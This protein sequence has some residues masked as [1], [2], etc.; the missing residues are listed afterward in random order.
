MPLGKL[1]NLSG[2]LLTPS[3]SICLK[4]KCLGRKETRNKNAC[5]IPTSPLWP[6][7]GLSHLSAGQPSSTADPALLRPPPAALRLS[8]TSPGRQSWLRPPGLNYRSQG[9]VLG[10]TLT[11]SGKR[12]WGT[13]A[14]HRKSEHLAIFQK[15]N[16]S[17]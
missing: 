4:P 17:P 1:V 9:S 14:E 3:G 7:A 2:P 5:C 12:M 13:C 11:S 15:K 8:H 10:G 6:S 16:A